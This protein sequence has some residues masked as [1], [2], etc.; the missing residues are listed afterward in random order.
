MN[1]LKSFCNFPVVYKDR[2]FKMYVNVILVQC[3]IKQVL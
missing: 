1:I 3:I 2:N